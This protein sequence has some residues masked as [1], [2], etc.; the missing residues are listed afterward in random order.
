MQKQVKGGVTPTPQNQDRAHPR[1]RILN[2][3][4]NYYPGRARGAGKAAAAATTTAKK[5]AREQERVLLHG[6][7]KGRA[8]VGSLC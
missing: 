2:T 4:E 6:W 7:V 5:E 1:H 8:G 3:K